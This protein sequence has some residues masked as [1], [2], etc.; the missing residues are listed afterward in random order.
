LDGFDPDKFDDQHPL[1]L[2]KGHEQFAAH[3]DKECFN[4]VEGR[5]FALSTNSIADPHFVGPNAPGVTGLNLSVGTGLA[6]AHSGGGAT[7]GAASLLSAP[8]QSQTSAS[9]S[10]SASAASGGNKVTVA[11][12]SSKPPSKKT[13][14]TS[15][16][17][18]TNGAVESKP[19]GGSKK[20]NNGPTPTASASALRKLMEEGGEFAEKIKTCIIRAAVHASRLGKHGQSFTAPNSQTYPDVSKAFAAHAGLKP[21][22]RCKNNKQGVSLISG[23]YFTLWKND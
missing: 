7:S 18:T 12:Q 3:L 13:I 20:K 10:A 11:G 2:P 9:A 5:Y 21:C 22:I 8:S 14:P 23:F 19:S 1:Y 4:I 15:S 17:N 16:S 6:T